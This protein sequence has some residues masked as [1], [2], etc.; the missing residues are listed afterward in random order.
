LKE[1]LERV[2]EKFDGKKNDEDA[3]MTSLNEKE[4][5]EILNETKIP[6][7]IDVAASGFTKEKIIIIK[8][9][10]SKEIQK[11]NLNI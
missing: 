10:N 4:I 6:F 8:I 1:I 3:W 7:G 9:R 5:L 11:N 2:D